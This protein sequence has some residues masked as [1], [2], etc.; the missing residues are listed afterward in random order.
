MTSVLFGVTA[1]DP[2]TYLGAAALAL[3]AAIPAAWVPMRRASHIDPIQSLR[4]T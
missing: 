1:T 3:A 4:R 2:L